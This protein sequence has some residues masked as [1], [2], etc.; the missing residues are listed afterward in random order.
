MGKENLDLYIDDLNYIKFKQILVKHNWIKLINNIRNYKFI[1]HYFLFTDHKIYHLHIYNKIIT[2]DSILKE[3][4]FTSLVKSN[5]KFF[6]KD[7]NLWILDFNMQLLLF[8]LRYFI[9]NSNLLGRYIYK[10]QKNSYI[11][12]YK[13]LKNSIDIN[14]LFFLNLKKKYFFDHNLNIESSTI[15]NALSK[16]I[17]NNIF[18]YKIRN[19]SEI[20][21]IYFNFSINLF[22]KK[23]FNKKNFRLQKGFSIFISG[24]D[25]SGKSTLVRNLN[26][27][28]SKKID[29]KVYNIAK[30]YPNFIINLAKKRN[31]TKRT[32]TKNINKKSNL[33][34]NIISM[35]KNIN[36]AFLRYLI[37]RK[38]KKY[39]KLNY[40]IICDRYISKNIGEIN[41]PRI[42]IHSKN[43]LVN[44]CKNLE[45]FF[46]K[47]IQPLDYEIRLI[48]EL[49]IA[50]NRNNKRKKGLYKNEEEII[51]RYHLFEK[52]KFESYNK[53]LYN[54]NHKLSNSIE[55]VLLITNK[56]IL[57]QT[58]DNC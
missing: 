25:A 40:L 21:N 48:T 19:F 57:S 13:N 31:Y 36:L 17:L 34:L 47:K 27:I 42:S 2:G 20:I 12:E 14:G 30:P 32:K 35:S 6:S 9:K 43:I 18:K 41:G 10:K 5:D 56:M 58:N 8:Y 16:K 49:K 15:D 29:V 4:D 22:L 33:H 11:E 37:Y 38:I 28:Y 50:I 46:Y 53:C 44:F 54:N 23:I 24:C 51:R 7:Y 55:D 52:S 26:T 45:L 39:F 3:Y 1:D